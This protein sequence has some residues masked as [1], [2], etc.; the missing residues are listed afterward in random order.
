MCIYIRINEAETPPKNNNNKTVPKK[1]RVV[2][3][4][5][6]K[7]RVDRGFYFSCINVFLLLTFCGAR[8]ESMLRLEDGKSS[9]RAY[10]NCLKVP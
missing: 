10:P 3:N 8:V 7:P 6:P 2:R 4:E 1:R 5:K 9:F